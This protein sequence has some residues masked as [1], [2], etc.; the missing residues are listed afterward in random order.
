VERAEVYHQ[1]AVNECPHIIVTS[2]LEHLTA[3]VSKTSVDFVTVRI[4]VVIAV[5][6]PPKTI[7]REKRVIQ[8]P[9]CVRRA[10]SEHN[11]M[12]EDK[13][14]FCGVEPVVESLRGLD[15]LSRASTV[16]GIYG[17]A[18]HANLPAVSK[19]VRRIA[20][21]SHEAFFVVLVIAQRQLEIGTKKPLSA[22]GNSSRS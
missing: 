2:E 21:R 9:I 8:I 14:L 20:L 18:V 12:I 13:V 6:V 7:E 1:L 15:V 4:V 22:I 17:G 16:V 10:Q 11:R 19:I 5:V 3:I